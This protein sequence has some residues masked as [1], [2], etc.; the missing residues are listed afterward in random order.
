MVKDVGPLLEGV[1]RGH[2]DR[3]LLI[4]Q[5]HDLEEQIGACLVNRQIAERSDLETTGRAD[6]G[7]CL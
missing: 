7:E 5:R 1:I 3:S 6:Y 4:A 2:D